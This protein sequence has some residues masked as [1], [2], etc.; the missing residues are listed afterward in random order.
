MSAAGPF[1]SGQTREARDMRDARNDMVARQIEAR[2]VRDAR[3]LDAMRRVPRELFVEAGARRHA[4]A[5]RPLPIGCGQ[6][7]SQPFIVAFMAQAAE[8]GPR[9]TVLEVGTG[10]GYAA[11]VLARLAARVVSVERHASLART[12]TERL[13]LA[14]ID[15]VAVHVAD[16]CE[17]WPDEAPFDAILVAAAAETVP[18]P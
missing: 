6:T 13:S 3:V 18:T 7:I 17:G 1:R 16:G 11:A 10:S 14:G 4:H 15:N 9:D 5:D 8:I 12:A 2:G